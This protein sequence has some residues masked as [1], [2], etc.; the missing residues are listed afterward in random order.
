MAETASSTPTILVVDD[1]SGVRAVVCRVL[2]NEGY[3][4]INAPDGAEALRVARAHHAPLDLL[5]TDL[6]MPGINGRELADTLR[7]TQPSLKVLFLT[8]YADGLF[9]DR[10]LLEENTAYLE[11]PVSGKGLN[12]AVRLLLYGSLAGKDEPSP[13]PPADLPIAT[14]ET[15]Y[16]SVPLAAGGSARVLFSAADPSLADIEEVA[17]ALRRHFAARAARDQAV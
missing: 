9:A 15:E 14:K 7:Q 1:E 2:S 4:V 12:E 6:K 5:L 10:A 16:L 11:K 8:A 13:A 17:E 3:R